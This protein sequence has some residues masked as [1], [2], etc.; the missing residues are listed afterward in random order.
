[1]FISIEGVPKIQ[2][3]HSE[4]SEESHVFIFKSKNQKRDPSAYGP[5][6][7]AKG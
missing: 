5:R 1:M 3:R 4:R 6:M 2:H 7:T